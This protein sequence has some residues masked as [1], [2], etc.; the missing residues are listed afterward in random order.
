MVQELAQAGHIL[1]HNRAEVLV[2][3]VEGGGRVEGGSKSGL[4]TQQSLQVKA[5]H[6]TGHPGQGLLD[7]AQVKVLAGTRFPGLAPRGCPRITDGKRRALPG[8]RRNEGLPKRFIDPTGHRATDIGD[9]DVEI[10]LA[11]EAWWA[12]RDGAR[13]RRVG[14]GEQGVKQAGNVKEP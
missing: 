9:P 7:L 5:T 6:D 11:Q 2:V 1:H 3:E 4:A 14:E 10:L 12:L 13:A 8:L